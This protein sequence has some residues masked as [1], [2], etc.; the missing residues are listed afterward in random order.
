MDIDDRIQIEQ[1][2]QQLNQELKQR[3]KQRTE[4]LEAVFDRAAV[5]MNLTSPEGTFIKV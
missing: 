4:T 2:L 5:G 3:V 1:A